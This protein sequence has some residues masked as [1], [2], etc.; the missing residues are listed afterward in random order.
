MTEK[1]YQKLLEKLGKTSLS[2]RTVKT[3]AGQLAKTV[4]KDE[5]LTDEVISNAVETLKAL[6]GQY[7][8]DLAEAIKNNPPKQTPPKQEPPK[9][10]PPK[11]EPFKDYEKRIADLEE[12]S[13]KQEERYERE[14]KAVKLKNIS[15]A[16][17]KQ[18]QTSGCNNSLVLELAFAKSSIDTEKSVDDNAKS[19]RDLYDSLFKENLESGMIPRS[20]EI[21]VATV[22]PEDREKKAKE[23]M[24]RLKDKFN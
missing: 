22:S 19:V 7:D 13:R 9:T 21:R 23:D 20:A 3:Y 14:I 1:I 18:L 11:D 8:H 16:V 6:G 4:T 10:E 2:E 12:K 15:D 24:E 5:E 17:K